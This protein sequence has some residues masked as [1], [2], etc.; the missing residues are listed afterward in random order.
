MLKRKENQFK[1]LIKPQCL[2][3]IPHITKGVIKAT[4][5]QPIPAGDSLVRSLKSKHYI[6]QI[7]EV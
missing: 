2:Q 1:S 6:L 7:F 4:F 5:K 3:D